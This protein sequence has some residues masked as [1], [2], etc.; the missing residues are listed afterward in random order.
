MA[1]DLEFTRRIGQQPHAGGNQTPAAMGCPDVW[2]LSNGDFAVIGIRKTAELGSRLP[3]SASCGPDEEIVVIPRKTL[4]S[5]K[6][7]IPS[8]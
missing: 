6:K 5:A 1:S 2:E 8:S 4:V 3:D 7:D